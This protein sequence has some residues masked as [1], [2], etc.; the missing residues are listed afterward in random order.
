MKARKDEWLTTILF[1]TFL[2]IMPLLFWLLPK[3]E[4]SQTE[5]RFLEK[6][7][8]L[9]AET[10]S[11]GKFGNDAEKYMADHLPGRNF[12]VGLNAYVDLCSGKQV[13]KDI[14]VANNNRLV[15][16]PV[17]WDQMQVDKNINAISTF[18]E[19]LGRPV[20]FM[21][22]PSAGW[23]A[24][25]QI[26]GLYDPY[27]DAEI[28]EDIYNQAKTDNVIYRELLHVFE[29]QPQLYYK[30]DH[31]WTSEGAYKAYAAYMEEKGREYPNADQFAVE[32]V[33]GFRGTTYSRS[34]LWLTPAES[35]QLWTYSKNL[36]VT[37]NGSEDVHQGAFYKERLKDA[38]MYTVFLN[39]T[40]G[41]IR[42][43]NPDN[44][45]KGSILVI[46]DSYSSCF[47]PML[48]ESYETVILLDMRWTDQSALE[49]CEEMDFDD[50]L[51]CYSLSNFMTDSNFYKLKY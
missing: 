10:L 36:Q 20:E 6:A 47:A 35:V 46:R 9:S 43:D 22:V 11:S 37:I 8:V 24:K 13:T 2:G 19:K 51:I 21:L 45:G 25:E 16:A 38:D 40:Q 17:Q 28:I 30:T 18:A 3:A 7:P 33:D 27:H 49:L 39:G 15:E 50:V 5:K 32:T 44:V 12:F 14:Y 31:H 1:C 26:K 42:I 4:F 23:A 34:A 29:N 48:A 41:M